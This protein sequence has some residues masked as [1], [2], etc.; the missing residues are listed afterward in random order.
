[1]N[2][3]VEVCLEGNAG[4]P[5]EK[6][7]VVIPRCGRLGSTSLS[8]PFAAFGFT[9]AHCPAKEISPSDHGFLGAFWAY[10]TGSLGPFHS[11]WALPWRQLDD[12]AVSA[13]SINGWLRSLL[14]TQSAKV[15]QAY[16]TPFSAYSLVFFTLHRMPR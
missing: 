12:W 10:N 8:L 4:D 13:T 2:E 5:P 7:W 16:G 15:I 1:M 14:W 9:V 3:K 6:A 11:F